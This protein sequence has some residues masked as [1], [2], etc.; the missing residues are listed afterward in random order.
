MGGCEAL[1]TYSYWNR[2]SGEAELEEAEMQGKV[3][4]RV[5]LYFCLPLN[6]HKTKWKDK[7][8]NTLVSYS[9]LGSVELRLVQ[10]RQRQTPRCCGIAHHTT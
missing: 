1:P 5:N 9:E 6:V 4:G 10:C 3:K 2:R 7:A 8:R